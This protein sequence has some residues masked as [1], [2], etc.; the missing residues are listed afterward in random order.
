MGQGPQGNTVYT[1]AQNP[2]IAAQI[3]GGHNT[4]VSNNVI[5]AAGRNAGKDKKNLTK[6]ELER[7]RLKTAKFND[8]VNTQL[9]GE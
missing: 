5:A 7:K 2:M 6:D 8:M 1:P 9:Q 3:R 4:V